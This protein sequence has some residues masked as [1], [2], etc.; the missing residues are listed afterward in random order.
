MRSHLANDAMLKVTGAGLELL[1]DPDM[2][3]FFEESKRGGVSLAMKRYI[4]A[5]NKYMKN[6]DPEKPSTYIEYLDENALYTSILAGP[7]PYSGF[8]WLTEEEI[9]EMM[10]DHT[11]IKSFARGKGR[12]VD[13][14]VPVKVINKDG[15]RTTYR[16]INAAAET[17]KISTMEV[18]TMVTNGKAS[19]GKSIRETL[20][21]PIRKRRGLST[22]YIVEVLSEDGTVDRV[23]KSINEAA[24]ILK[25]Y[26]NRVYTMIALGKA[27][28]VYRA[29]E[30][31]EEEE[32]EEE[33]DEEEGEEEDE[34]EVVDYHE[35]YKGKEEEVKDLKL[36]LLLANV[37]EMVH[38]GAIL[39]VL[40]N[41]LESDV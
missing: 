32:I 6:Y 39:D 28:L 35:L 31:E 1:T 20:T 8:T 15:T 5:N 23:F 9:N 2:H 41:S 7:L 34:E 17:L 3:L 4:K 25:V 13:I 40:K 27:R 37:R 29:K 33:E 24:R 36:E 16:S 19:F 10:E 21:Y 38:T 18:Y 22:E 12:I 26:S 14:R 30:G 11:K